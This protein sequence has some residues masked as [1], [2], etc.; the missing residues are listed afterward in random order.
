M[1]T[2]AAVAAHHQSGEE[3]QQGQSQED[4]QTGGV[5]HPLVVFLCS[6]APDL[7][8]KILDA[9]SFPIHGFGTGSGDSFLIWLVCGSC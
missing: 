3:D 4:H 9:V 1:T 8:E 2:A 6:K 7:V 5:V